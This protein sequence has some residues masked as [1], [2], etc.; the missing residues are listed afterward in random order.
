MRCRLENESEEW[1]A[2]AGSD[3]KDYRIKSPPRP[4]RMGRAQ[5]GRNWHSI[6]Q[7]KAI[8]GTLQ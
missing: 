6:I 2:G 1:L 8:L 4:I 5:Y 7:A 3:A